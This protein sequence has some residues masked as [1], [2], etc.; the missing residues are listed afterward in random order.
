VTALDEMATR[1]AA[2]TSHHQMAVLRDD[3]L[4]RHVQ[5]VRVAP[6]AETGKPE[7]SSFYWFELVTWPGHL[8]IT[9]DCGTFTF[10]RIDD[11][12]G[13]F[14]RTR[15]SGGVSPQYWS[16]KVQGDVRCKRY[17]PERFRQLVTEYTGDRAFQQEY[18][19]LAE[20]IDRDIFGPGS[21]WNVEWGEDQAREALAEFT[22]GDTWKGA[23]PSCD[24]SV[25]GLPEADARSWASQH[26][27]QAGTGH[28]V[29]PQMVEGFRFTGTWEWD[30]S[31]WDWQYLWCCYAVQW[32]VSRYDSRQAPKPEPAAA[33]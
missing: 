22:F 14:R 21:E 28:R 13:F 9:G 23:C 31:D 25:K 18:P 29:D 26:W 32:G 17:S 6:D 27:A 24:A 8:T 10:A 3:G 20:A 33:S 15:D 19:G 2:D 16:E 12:F 1:F 7:R 30:L 4:Y 11:M 5:F